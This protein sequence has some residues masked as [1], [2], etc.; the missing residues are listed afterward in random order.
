[1]ILL[2]GLTMS[3]VMCSSPTLDPI[4]PIEWSD[5]VILPA[6]TRIVFPEAIRVKMGQT[7]VE[8][9]EWTTDTRCAIFTSRYLRRIM[10]KELTKF[11]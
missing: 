11:K 9:V 6:G 4:H 3:I 10:K 8:V 1:M 5:V 2:I 7:E